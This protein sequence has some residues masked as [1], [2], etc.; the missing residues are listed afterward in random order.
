VIDQKAKQVSHSMIE[1]KILHDRIDTLEVRLSYQDEVIE[2][3]NKTVTAQWKQIDSLGRQLAS[4]G[5]R[6]SETESSARVAARE[7][8]PPHY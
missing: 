1:A 3:L 8:P 4:L 5:D 6:L 7:P 2:A